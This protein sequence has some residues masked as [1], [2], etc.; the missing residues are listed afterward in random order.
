M[1]VRS[2]YGKSS[3]LGGKNLGWKY[4]SVL[5]A[6]CELQLIQEHRENQLASSTK[7]QQFRIQ[8]QRTSIFNDM[9]E[10]GSRASRD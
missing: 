6:A 8:H 10:Q 7:R 3:E 2:S 1:G 5:S 4:K 9:L